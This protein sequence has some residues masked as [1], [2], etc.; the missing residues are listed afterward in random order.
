LDAVDAARFDHRIQYPPHFFKSRAHEVE[1][2]G[3]GG[4]GL[5]EL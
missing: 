1:N 4:S 3:P 5:D 2:M